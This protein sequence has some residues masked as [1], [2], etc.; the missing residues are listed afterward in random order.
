MSESE[1]NSQEDSNSEDV[2]RHESEPDVSERINAGAKVVDRPNP[3]VVFEAILKQVGSPSTQR[4]FT[5]VL[6]QLLKISPGNEALSE[7][8]WQTV[9]KL[10]S[11]AAAVASEEDAHKLLA[12]SSSH[13]DGIDTGGY[14]Q[15]NSTDIPANNNTTPPSET[16]PSLSTTPSSSPPSQTR[17]IPPAIMSIAPPPP[18][19][20]PI[21]GIAWGPPPPPPPFN[22]A[23]PNASVPDL[24]QFKVPRPRSKMKT[25]QWQK[26]SANNV[27]GTS[28]IWTTIAQL[29]NKYEMDYERMDELFSLTNDN[30]PK[31]SSPD[32]GG[33]PDVKKKRE[34]TEEQDRVGVKQ[35]RMISNLLS[36]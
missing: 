17:Y 30:G 5:N 13:T 11:Q 6:Q 23:L 20:P 34:N 26:I 12:C 18:P 15:I 32:I 1:P 29:E 35:V 22:G 3:Q 8:I 7:S 4:A 36:I 10:V 33:S 28:N 25:L 2:A 9:E 21:P 19:P 14:Q 27:I 16:S 31:R 24:P